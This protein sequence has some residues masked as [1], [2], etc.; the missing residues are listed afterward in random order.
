MFDI[1]AIPLVWKK[2]N[3]VWIPKTDKNHKYVK[4]YRPVALLS[5]VGKL[6]ERIVVRRLRWWLV[7]SNWVDWCQTGFLPG[8]TTEEQLLHLLERAYEAIN[9][10]GVLFAVYLDISGAFNSICEKGCY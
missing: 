7:Q 9:N 10:K 8:H 3:I 4:N 1:G 6:M 2:C 5:L